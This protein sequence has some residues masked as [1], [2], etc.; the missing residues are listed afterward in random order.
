MPTLSLP[1]TVWLNREWDWA[2]RQKR[3]AYERAA[4]MHRNAHGGIR[5][6]LAR[7]KATQEE[8]QRAAEGR[9]RR[10]SK[11]RRVQGE[12]RADAQTSRRNVGE[13]EPEEGNSGERADQCP[14]QS[15]M[16]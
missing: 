2:T 5:Q 1:V 6:A 15:P 13:S 8:A 11:R 4:R 12:H 3:L 10:A 14:K 7:E 9:R 16:G